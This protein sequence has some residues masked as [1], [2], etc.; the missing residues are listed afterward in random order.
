M[1]PA[2]AAAAFPPHACPLKRPHHHCRKSLRHL[3]QLSA[4]HRCICLVGQRGQLTSRIPKLRHCSLQLLFCCWLELG[5]A[6][7]TALRLPLLPCWLGCWQRQQ[8]CGVV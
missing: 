7:L 5:L 8:Q 4:V 3:C 6:W 1:P 2:S